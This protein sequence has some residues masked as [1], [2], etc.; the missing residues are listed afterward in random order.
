MYLSHD[1]YSGVLK[2]KLGVSII[3]VII[4]HLHSCLRVVVEGPSGIGKSTLCCKMLNID[5]ANI[6]L[7]FTVL[8]RRYVKHELDRDDYFL[9]LNDPRSLSYCEVM[10]NSFS[11]L[12]SFRFSGSICSAWYGLLW[13]PS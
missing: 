4:N 10:M 12:R 8:C 13:S 3:G 6:P 5:K 11:S 7:N 2:L 9:E 1:R